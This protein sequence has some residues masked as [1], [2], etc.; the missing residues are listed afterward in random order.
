MAKTKVTYRGLSDERI[1]PFAV[2]K[3][4]GVTGLEAD[5][6]LVFTR[7]G[8]GRTM[9]I[10]VDDKLKEI[11][12]ADGGFEIGEA[13]VAST[14]EAPAETVVNADTGQVDKRK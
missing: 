8:A 6:D 9:E 10:E 5:K 7:R 13:G 4:R 14:T 12:E 2:L 1:L 3:E 11:L